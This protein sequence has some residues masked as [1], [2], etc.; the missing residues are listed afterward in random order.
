MTQI[1]IYSFDPLESAQIIV[2]YT[3]PPP[4]FSVNLVKFKPRTDVGGGGGSNWYSWEILTLENTYE[5]ILNEREK[6]INL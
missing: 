2:N 5:Q 4:S 6:V 3:H 1:F